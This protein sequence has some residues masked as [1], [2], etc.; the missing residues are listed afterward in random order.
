ME[1]FTISVITI[2]D[3]YEDKLPYLYESLLLNTQN[4]I[5]IVWNIY[6]VENNELAKNII[7]YFEDLEEGKDN[8]FLR[9]K[10]IYG[11]FTENEAEKELIKISYGDFLI[12]AKTNNVFLGDAFKKLKDNVFLLKDING[13]AFLEKN[14]DKY[15]CPNKNIKITDLI[16]K[17]NKKNIPLFYNLKI[18]K[19]LIEKNEKE[20]NIKNKPR[21]YPSLFN[22][23]LDKIGDIFAINIPIMQEILDAKEK[24]DINKQNK[25]I[26]IDYPIYFKNYYENLFSNGFKYFKL[27][28]VNLNKMVEK[29]S[30]V[31]YILDQKP[32]LEKIK[33]KKIIRYI[34]FKNFF[35][36]I[37]YKIKFKNKE[38][39]LKKNEYIEKEK[40]K[41]RYLK[42]S[43]IDKLNEN[44]VKI[45]E[46]KSEDINI[47]DLNNKK[48]KEK[49]EKKEK[50]E[51]LT[52]KKKISNTDK[53]NSDYNNYIKNMNMLKDEKNK[54]NEED[55]T[56]KDK[57]D[58]LEKSIN[59]D[60][61]NYEKQKTDIDFDFLL[62]NTALTKKLKTIKD[63]RKVEIQ[64]KIDN[65]D[66]SKNTTKM[67]LEI[68]KKLEKE[69]QELLKEKEL[70]KQK[71]KLDEE[72]KREIAWNNLLNQNFKDETK[73]LDIKKVK[74]EK[75][76]DK[77]KQEKEQNVEKTNIKN[78]NLNGL[79]DD[80]SVKI[81]D[82][83]DEKKEKYLKIIK[84]KKEKNETKVEDYLFGDE[85]QS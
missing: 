39:D 60:L 46:N 71:Q 5:N 32:D 18:L 49:K 23:E 8:G 66:L 68:L 55:L 80:G 20:D 76:K 50:K 31:L 42:L 2:I 79:N 52:T 37:K 40:L 15:I 56:L 10:T 35:Y 14:M 48:Q 62:K 36:K 13:F 22:F 17:E 3:E 4:N 41:D 6:C 74:E 65:S 26:I 51:D 12:N 44:N 1:K 38:E 57:L 11:N 54:K 24:E 67:N 53:N 43:K 27:S 7:E 83:L 19:N 73:V 70:K 69:E 21:N 34:L 45:K 77:N 59:E 75:N 33:D 28:N 58:F 61:E 25:N 16:V 84:N 47:E 81:L 29:Y 30:L 9:I 82:D 72:R 64:D 78:N 63:E 85:F